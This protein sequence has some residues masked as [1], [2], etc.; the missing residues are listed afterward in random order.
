MIKFQCENCEEMY[1][2]DDVVRRWSTVELCPGCDQALKDAAEKKITRVFGMEIKVDP[3][4]KPNEIRMVG[5][6]GEV[7]IFNIG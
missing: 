1:P 6:N 5:A 2:A 4:L 3:K 7:A